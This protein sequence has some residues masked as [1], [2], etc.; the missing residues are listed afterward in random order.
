MCE[1]YIISGDNYIILAD[2]CS[3]SEHSEMG[4]RFLCYMA[5]EFMKRYGVSPLESGFAER[6][7]I[8]VIHN[9]EMLI[10]QL[11]LKKTSLDA[12]LIVAYEKH[13]A[14]CIH[15]FGDGCVI[16]EPIQGA[17]KHEIFDVEYK[18]GPRSMPFY[19]RY[20]IDQ[21]GHSLYHS[22]KVVK[23]LYKTALYDP[24]LYEIHEPSQRI[25]EEIAYDEINS[26]MLPI[27]EYKSI[28]ITSDGLSTFLRPVADETGNKIMKVEAI[29]PSMFTFKSA[30]GVFLQR[31]I[32]IYKR[33]LKKDGLLFD[34]FDDLSIG[35]FHMEETPNAKESET[36]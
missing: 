30:S 2:G 12:T 34:H 28:S 8:W 9:A 36:E 11:G 31:Q 19:L 24:G 7:G 15:M 1:D 10:R 16:L 21:E 17:I 6:M 13:D 35:T 33:K 32:N 4:A 26:F 20:Y 22:A 25:P 5:K 29:V 3:S 18:A 27:N 14:I 23:T